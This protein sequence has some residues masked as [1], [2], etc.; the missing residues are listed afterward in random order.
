MAHQQFIDKSSKYRDMRNRK[1]G[2]S[3]EYIGNIDTPMKQQHQNMSDV[4]RSP[5]GSFP[6]RYANELRIHHYLR[7]NPINIQ[8][9]I[10]DISRSHM[11]LSDSVESFSTTSYS[12]SSQPSGTERPTI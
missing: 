12:S 4:P 3:N 9:W 2:I 7:S 11:Q 5:S 6:T 1:F 8:F 10:A